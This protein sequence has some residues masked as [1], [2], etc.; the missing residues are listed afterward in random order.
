MPFTLQALD[1]PQRAAHLLANGRI[2]AGGTLVVADLNYGRLDT[3]ALVTL[4][5]LGLDTIEIAG[6][7]VTICAMVTM[8]QI[9]ECRRLQFLH[10]VARSIGGPAVRAMA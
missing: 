8:A 6:G 7:K 2:V 4:D 1:K 10:P 5:R 9:A 3:E